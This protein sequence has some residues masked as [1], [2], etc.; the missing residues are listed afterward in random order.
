MQQRDDLKKDFYKI[1]S[2]KEKKGVQEQRYLVHDTEDDGVDEA[3]PCHPHQTQQ[4]QVSIAVQ[5][6]VCGFRVEDGA[7]ELA[8]LCT[9]ACE[10][11]QVMTFDYF[12]L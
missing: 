12:R 1:M 7:H 3:D 2:Q 6:E 8:F 9:E 5:L 4:E 10:N 11:T